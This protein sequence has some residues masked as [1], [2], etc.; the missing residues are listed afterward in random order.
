MDKDTDKL[1]KQIVED[2]KL[3]NQT[4]DFEKLYQTYLKCKTL[5]AKEPFFFI[6]NWLKSLLQND[7]LLIVNGLF[8]LLYF[9]ID[10]FD[11][12]KQFAHE[13]SKSFP[14]TETWEKIIEA[15]IWFDFSQQDFFKPL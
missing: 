4:F 14:D 3:V 2:L 15:S 7:E 13:A 8:A 5:I 9:D 1:K 12:A 6:E 10:D 11:K